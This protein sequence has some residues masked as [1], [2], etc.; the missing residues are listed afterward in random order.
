[1]TLET[2]GSLNGGRKIWAL[3]RIGEDF[4]VSKGDKVHTYTLL[5][6]SCDHS[7]SSTGLL[8]SQRVVCANTLNMALRQGKSAA[9]R[10]PHSTKF[11][12]KKVQVQMGLIKESIHQ[13]ANIMSKMAKVGV[14]DEQAMRFFIEL[15]KTPEEKRTGKVDLTTKRRAIPKIWN[16]YKGAPGAED[17]VWGLV[18]AVTHSV[19]YNPHSQSD[20]SRLDS[21]WFGRGAAQKT[22]AYEMASD[23][24]I[25]DAIVDNTQKNQTSLDRL[26][27]TVSH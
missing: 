8:T 20:S 14:N 10:V 12:H 4:E 13:N 16:S 11:D 18:N 26:L 9:I 19:D 2:A 24:N 27:A 3:A 15:L 7:I 23:E 17:T 22:K 1:M 6:S 21:A 5:A 25:L